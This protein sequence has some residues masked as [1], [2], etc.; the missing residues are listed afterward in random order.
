MAAT[1][2]QLPK[3]CT[4][5]NVNGAEQ[6]FLF[7][8]SHFVSGYDGFKDQYQTKGIDA[9]IYILC[10]QIVNKQQWKA[11]NCLFFLYMYYI[12][13]FSIDEYRR[14]GLTIEM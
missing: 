6:R 10:E 4:R 5:R 12:L 2:V 7:D 9:R 8:T 3:T 14:G 13:L 11:L 1:R